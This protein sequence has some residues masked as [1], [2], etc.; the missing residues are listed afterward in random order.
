MR[1]PRKLL[2]VLAIGI[3]TLS[4]AGV[5]AAMEA[6]PA[7]QAPP[8]DQA[9]PDEDEQCPDGTPEGD[10]DATDE[11]AEA[12]DAVEGASTGEDDDCDEAEVEADDD[13]PAKDEVDEGPADVPVVTSD[14]HPDNHG[15]TV[16][17][18]AHT[19]PTG[20]AHGACV[21][22]VARSDAGKNH[23]E[24]DGADDADDADDADE[25]HARSNGKGDGRG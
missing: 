8:V 11:G 9:L 23:Q 3:A 20:P 2:P 7:P 6:D 4:F 19:C 12:T 24:S 5:S 10:E 25:L 18:A 16:S 13:D 17:E 21:S 22:E 15:A 1:L 14:L